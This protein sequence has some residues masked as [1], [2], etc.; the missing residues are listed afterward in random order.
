MLEKNILD[1]KLRRL[2][3]RSKMSVPPI[4]HFHTNIL[5]NKHLWLI[6]S[7]SADPSD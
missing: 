1:R 5:H 2:W 7:D 3:R 6:S 4:Q